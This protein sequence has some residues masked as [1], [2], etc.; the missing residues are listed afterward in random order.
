MPEPTVNCFVCGVAVP[1]SSTT[2]EQHERA[3]KRNPAGAFLC[4]ECEK[5]EPR[6]APPPP[7]AEEPILRYFA[8]EHLQSETLRDISRLFAHLA[9]DLVTKLPR[10][11]ERSVA[12]RKL[13]EG[14]DAAV[15]AALP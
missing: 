12:L 7:S 1:F 15:R 14:K 10:N 5:N 3:Q 11:P 6:A 2:T 13:L 4:A 8:W 9:R